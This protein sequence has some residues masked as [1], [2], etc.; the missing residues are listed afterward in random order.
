MRICVLALC[1]ALIQAHA[2]RVSAQDDPPGRSIVFFNATDTPYDMPFPLPQDAE[3]DERNPW[4]AFAMS[5]VI[6]GG[7]QFYNKQ[8][9][10]GVA[11]F[12][13][14]AVGLGLLLAD[15]GDDTEPLGT[16]DP[17]DRGTRDAIGAA[18]FL[19]GA[20]WSMID[21]PISANAINRKLSESASFRVA[22]MVR[23]D[24][25]GAQLTLSF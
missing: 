12:S 23:H 6:T 24:R 4:I 7:G 21:A 9:F 19:G 14:S 10:K 15:T 17:E 20:L 1:L 18:M 8:Y 2:G 22:P 5:A 3:M 13:L 25:I 16:D 11:Q